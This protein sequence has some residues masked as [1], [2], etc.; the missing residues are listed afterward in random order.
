M[1]QFLDSSPIA[2]D[3]EQLKDRMERDGYLFIRGLLPAQVLEELRLQFLEIALQVGWL[4]KGAPLA[5]GL[6]DLEGFC[7][8]PEPQ[9]MEKYHHMY[10]LP[11]FHALQHRTELVALLE[12]VLGE[13]VLP[14]PRLIGRTIF[15]Q[16][17]AYTTP[18]H[19]DFIPIQG[20]ADTYTAWIPLSTLSA[21]MGGLQI[22]AG[23]HRA[24]V[25]DFRPALGAGGLEVTAAL[26]GTWVSGSFDQGDVLFFHSMAVH[27]G[28]ANTGEKLRMSIDARYQKVSDPIAPGSL[29]PHSQ[30]HSWDEIYAGWPPDG[31]QYYWKKY[32]LEIAAYDTSYHD[33]RD[34]L[35]LQMAAEGDQNSLSTLQRI[36]ARDADPEK[37]QRARELIEALATEK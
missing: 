32:D 11:E 34:Q 1:R 28:V 7:V 21:E 17:Q 33:K 20:T 26:D 8:E 9:Y 5:A 13:P 6:A 3:G 14:H 25:Y 22:A 35:A 12:R 10:C 23:S 15:P 27:K 18:A 36:V 24:G 2:N 31:L 37:R 30:P 19:Q 29:Q 4:K 16:R